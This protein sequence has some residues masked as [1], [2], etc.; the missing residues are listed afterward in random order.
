M[1]RPA[2]V[3]PVGGVMA[4]AVLILIFALFL[5]SPWDRS[6]Q[7]A[8]SSLNMV[9][10]SLPMALAKSGHS[11]NLVTV[12]VTI[13][14]IISA[15]AGA[16]IAVAGRMRGSVVTWAAG[17]FLFAASVAILMQPWTA[18]GFLGAVLLMLALVARLVSA[19]PM[20][21]LTAVLRELWP[22][23]YAVAFTVLAWRYEP[24]LLIQSLLIAL[25]LSLV[26][27]ALLPQRRA[28]ALYVTQR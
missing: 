5:W 1:T 21:A 26:A 2:R 25:G 6:T 20:S 19:E 9:W 28:A 18:V 16:L 12:S 23:G 27:R 24:R 22:V 17:F 10:L 14:G 15:C 3:A 7:A 8:T 11:L 13:C 4:D